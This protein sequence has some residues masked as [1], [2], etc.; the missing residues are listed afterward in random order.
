MGNH[1]GVQIPLP[2]QD[3]KPWVVIHLGFSSICA[4]VGHVRLGSYLP[5][6]TLLCPPHVA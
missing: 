1:P 2:P 6:S 4:G 5:S 3:G